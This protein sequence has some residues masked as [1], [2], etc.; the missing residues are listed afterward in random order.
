[1]QQNTLRTVSFLLVLTAITAVSY[2]SYAQEGT[3]KR[4][5]FLEYRIHCTGKGLRKRCAKQQ[6]HCEAY[7][8]TE[9]GPATDKKCTDWKNSF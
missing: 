6:R 9:G 4:R 3:V 7:Q 2:Q 1:M 5:T 8:S